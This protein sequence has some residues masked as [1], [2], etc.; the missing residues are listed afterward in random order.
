M[1]VDR[2]GLD[3]TNLSPELLREK[4]RELR[5]ACIRMAHQ[6]KESHLNGALSSVDILIAL[7]YGFLRTTPDNP[8]DPERDRFIFSKGHACTS[9]YAILADQGFFPKEWLARYATDDT[10]LPSHPCSHALPLLE[11][12]SG[13]LGHG[14]GVASDIAY[15]LRAKGSSSRACALISDGECNEGST[16]E[17]ASFASLHKLDNLLC[18]VDY[19]GIQSIGKTK[20]LMGPVEVVVKRFEAFGWG[21]R[22]V[23]GL[24]PSAMI[25]ILSGFPF[26]QGR[27]SALIAHTR[28]G[29]G[30]SFMEDQVLWHYR[31]PSADDLEKALKELG[32]S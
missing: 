13:S 17:T 26:E 20:D 22:Y 29:A 30:V 31:T 16:W 28:A 25:S 5:A 8:E 4:G 15:A 10:P 11:F 21:V 1:T 2:I 23:D 24:N 19:N 14:L 32:Q 3:P 6:G 7:Y 12:S 9:L 27:P 18:V